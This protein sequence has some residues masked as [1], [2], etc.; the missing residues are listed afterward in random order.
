MM[1]MARRLSRTA[2]AFYSPNDDSLV[3]G[4]THSPLPTS[5]E[6]AGPVGKISSP[7]LSVITTRHP[8]LAISESSPFTVITP[9]ALAGYA[10]PDDGSS[11]PKATYAFP[12]PPFPAPPNYSFPGPRDQQRRRS[13]T[14]AMRQAQELALLIEEEDELERVSRVRT[15]SI[16]SLASVAESTASEDTAGSGGTGASVSRRKKSGRS[17]MLDAF[18]SKRVGTSGEVPLLEVAGV[19]GGG[20][21]I[22]LLFGIGGGG[23]G[24]HHPHNSESNA[25]RKPPQRP[26]L[27][28]HAFSASQADVIA[29][30]PRRTSSITNLRQHAPALYTASPTELRRPSLGPSISSQLS[31]GIF[32]RPPPPNLNALRRPSAVSMASVASMV[33]AVEDVTPWELEPGPRKAGRSPPGKQGREGLQ[34]GELDSEDEEEEGRR[35]RTPRSP[36]ES[37]KKLL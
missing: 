34:E 30:P 7:P 9:R 3:T 4:A 5:T 28:P 26:S 18:R 36:G 31:P 16:A 24:G 1:L 29:S 25:P 19:Q 21:K 2:T 15:G 23:G 12:A 11:T 10:A 37:W 17:S 14:Q 8:S 35:A 6:P 33:S 13:S 22:G 27:P 32:D 20:S